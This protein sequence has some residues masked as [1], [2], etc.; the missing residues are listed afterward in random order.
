[1]SNRKLAAENAALAEQLGEALA[2]KAE[3]RAHIALIT[4]EANTIERLLE[5]AQL[6]LAFEA[7][8]NLPQNTAM[9][10]W[11]EIIAKGQ[12]VKSGPV[13]GWE[14]HKPP[15]VVFSGAVGAVRQSQGHVVVKFRGDPRTFVADID[16]G[17]QFL[18]RTAVDAR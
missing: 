1:M 16:G 10:G 14:H 13:E 18:L 6:A 8:K 3:Q 2:D 9:V 5:N 17:E 4:R 7:E 15:A 11:G 12:I